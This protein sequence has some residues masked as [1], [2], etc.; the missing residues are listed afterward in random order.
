MEIA[1]GEGDPRKL[2]EVVRGEGAQHIPEL[3][4]PIQSVVPGLLHE[5]RR[6]V[7]G[8]LNL[9][10]FAH[11]PRVQRREGAQGLDIDDP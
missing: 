7:A 9:A 2:A 3:T 11:A 5:K 6:A 8:R 10:E 1:A 4:S